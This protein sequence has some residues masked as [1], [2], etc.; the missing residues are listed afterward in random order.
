MLSVAVGAWLMKRQEDEADRQLSS[1]QGDPEF[2]GMKLAAASFYR[3]VIVAEAIGL[4]AGAT[5]GATLLYS[6]PESCFAA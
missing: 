6:I 1:G 5:L 3:E 2:L 4:K